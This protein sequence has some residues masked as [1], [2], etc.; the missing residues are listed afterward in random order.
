MNAMVAAGYLAGYPDGTLKPKASITR[1]EFATIMNRLVRQY[2]YP[3]SS[4]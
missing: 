2:I 3:G 4:Y 1:A